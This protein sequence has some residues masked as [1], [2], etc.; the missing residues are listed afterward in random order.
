MANYQGPERRTVVAFTRDDS[1]RLVRIEESVK[2][3]PDLIK[4]VDK[5]EAKQNWFA[6]IGAAIM[7]VI[8]AI[9]SYFEFH[10]GG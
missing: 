3:V 7:F 1:D 9:L 5:V 10:K 8:S 6:G 2:V 4:R